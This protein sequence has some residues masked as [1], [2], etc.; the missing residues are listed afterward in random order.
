[1]GV[2]NFLVEG[3]S[4]TGK[5]SVCK[6]L[7][8]RGYRAINGDT[9]LAYQGDPG[10]G[11]PTDGVTHGHHIWCVGKVSVLVADRT[12]PITFF[13]GGSRNVAKYL[14]MFDG[15]FILEVDI[16][17]VIRRLAARPEEEW[18]GKPSERELVMRLHRTR[19]DL[20]AKGMSIDATAPIA[21]V[22]DEIL[23]KAQH[24]SGLPA[25][26][27]CD[28]SYS[29]S[30]PTSVS[31]RTLSAGDIETLLPDR[32]TAEGTG[33]F[34]WFGFTSPT[35][36]R[37]KA[38]DDELVTPEGGILGVFENEQ[39]AGSVEWFR[40]LWGRADTS[41]CWTIAIALR[42]AFRGRGVGRIAQRQLVDYLFAHS[43]VHRVQAFTDVRNIAEQRALEA[44]G[45]V[46]E[47][48]VRQA[49]WRSGAWHD[50]VIYA[51]LR[52]D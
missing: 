19:E 21:R 23:R 52:G 7:Q 48:V 50:Q 39:L 42:P 47:G 16:D 29:A 1:M 37:S 32:D 13:C 28:I 11:E 2:T 44:A 3:V 41:W 43:V 36:L 34:Q 17:T 30:M 31:L 6:E 9:E 14:D 49:Q 20:P 38:A 46:R 10:T 12:Q 51:V 45:F 22:V 35:R 27:G 8:R 4:G 33:E 5:T 26:R 15:V 24:I 25:T 40:S 18:G